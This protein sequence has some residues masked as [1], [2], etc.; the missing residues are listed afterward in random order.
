MHK[1]CSIRGEISNAA[2]FQALCYARRSRFDASK[3]T[4]LRSL[5]YEM[6]ST[7]CC[8]VVIEACEQHGRQCPRHLSR[9]VP[10]LRTHC[11]DAKDVVERITDACRHR[12]AEAKIPDQAVQ[13]LK[14]VARVLNI[15]W[16]EDALLQP[17]R[18]ICP[19]SE[20]LPKNATLRQP[21]VPGRRDH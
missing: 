4:A 7:R 5:S 13:L 9:C 20:P 17:A 14:G 12:H 21:S 11:G 6:A 2:F 16:V 10:A 3:D 15:A 1:T 19:R 8:T 18:I